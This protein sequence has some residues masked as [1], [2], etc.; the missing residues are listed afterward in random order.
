M[1]TRDAGVL[2]PCWATVQLT[3]E[4]VGSVGL[5]VEIGGLLAEIGGLLAGVAGVSAGVAMVLRVA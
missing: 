3:D 2:V 5:A 1:A 4:R